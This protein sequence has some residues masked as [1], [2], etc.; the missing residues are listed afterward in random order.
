MPGPLATGTGTGSSA[1][2]HWQWAAVAL[3]WRPHWRRGTAR[4]LAPARRRFLTKKK[5]DSDLIIPPS[6]PKSKMKCFVEMQ[7]HLSHVSPANRSFP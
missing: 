4:R 2:S 7:P 3:P 1:T 6:S 5:D